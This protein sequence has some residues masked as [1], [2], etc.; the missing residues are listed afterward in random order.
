MAGELN[1]SVVKDHHRCRRAVVYVRQSTEEQARSNTGSTDYQRG[2]VRFAKA[3]GWPDE[4]IEVVEDDLGLGGTSAA[5]R[6]G[7]LRIKER[8]ERREIGAVLISD[9][10]R[11]GRDSEEW[12]AFLRLCRIYDV[13][14]I[15]DGKVHNPG[16]NSELLIA[17]ILAT[18]GE[19]DNLMRREHLQRGRLTKARQ[20]HTV[21]HPPCGYVRHTDGTWPKHPSPEVQGAVYAPFRI[22]L[23]VGSCP[24]TVQAM[25]ARGIKLPVHND[26]GHILRWV[27]AQLGSVYRMLRNPAYVG[28]YAFR[29]RIADPIRGRDR[30]GRLRMRPA[31]PEEQILIEEHHEPYVTAEEWQRVQHLMRLNAPSPERRNLGPGSAL[32][33]GNIRC[34]LHRN[35]AMRAMYTNPP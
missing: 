1:P 18:I 13:L 9:F 19:Y 14:I 7:Y 5:H 31:K 35:R 20:G 24:K 33:Q 17:K 30:R 26:R 32:L 22:F 6:H 2:Q 27:D 11:L 29:R 10:T 3:L 23:E 25:R 4:L 16:D 15:I 28:T 8:I 21:T 12:S 34:A